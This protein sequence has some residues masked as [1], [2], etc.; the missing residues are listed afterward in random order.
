MRD[1]IQAT[2]LWGKLLGI[3]AVLI[4]ALLTALGERD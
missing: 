3:L 1:D 4:V 2:V